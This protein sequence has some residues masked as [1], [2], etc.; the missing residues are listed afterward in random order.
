MATEHSVQIDPEVVSR[1][2]HQI[3]CEIAHQRVTRGD[4]VFEGP[5]DPFLLDLREFLEDLVPT[6]HREPETA[7]VRLFEMSEDTPQLVRIPSDQHSQRF[8]YG[9]KTYKF[10]GPTPPH[11]RRLS[12]EDMSWDYMEE[13]RLNDLEALEIK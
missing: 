10:T 8:K 11:I 6:V 3:E 1:H 2:L 5:A 12:D 9:D 13:E 7:L 4:A